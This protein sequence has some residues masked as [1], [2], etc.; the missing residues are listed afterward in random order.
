VSRTR[1]KK[2][3]STLTFDEYPSQFNSLDEFV[4]SLNAYEGDNIWQDLIYGAEIQPEEIDEERSN[5]GDGSVIYL[6]SGETIIYHE[7]EKTWR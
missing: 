7:S 1:R 5:Q 3:M 6:K 4:D 2:K